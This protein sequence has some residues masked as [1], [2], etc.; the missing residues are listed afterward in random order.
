M[1]FRL[2][3][4]VHVRDMLDVGLVDETWL[5]RMGGDLGARLQHLI[6]TPEG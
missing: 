1:A 6:D 3:D 5:P 4:R 2:I